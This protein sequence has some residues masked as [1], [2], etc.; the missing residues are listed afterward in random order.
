MDAIDGG[1][2][3]LGTHEDRDVRLGEVA[4]DPLED[5]LSQEAGDAREEDALARERID[6]RSGPSFLYHAADYA[7][8]TRW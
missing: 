5:H 7:L 1:R 3:L 4:Q 6:D 8:S 2:G